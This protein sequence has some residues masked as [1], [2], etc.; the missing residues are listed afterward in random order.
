MCMAFPACSALEAGFSLPQP[1]EK[2]LCAQG[3]PASLQNNISPAPSLPTF[4]KYRALV[5]DTSYRPIDIINWQRAIC[6]DIFDKVNT[7]Q[8]LGATQLQGSASRSGNA[9]I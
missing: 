9:T 1:A 2:P 8:L 3:E 6:L 4:N 5:L 7:G